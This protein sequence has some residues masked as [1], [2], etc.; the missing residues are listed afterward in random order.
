MRPRPLRAIGLR[1]SA[2]A[3]KD[4]EKNKAANLAADAS[5]LAALLV[6]YI[7]PLCAL[8]APCRPGAST[9]RMRPLC[10]DGALN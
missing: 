2:Y 1:A 10:P 9:P 3:A 8:L 7:V 4:P 6:A 5:R